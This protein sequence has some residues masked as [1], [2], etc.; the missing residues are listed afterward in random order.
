M[1]A[2]PA[3][4]SYTV[5]A[6]NLSHA[7]ENKIHDD[8]IAQKLGFTGGL[9]PGVE[10]YAYATHLALGRWGRA[11]LEGGAMDCRFQ[12]PVY[13]GAFATV[14]GID[15]GATIAL[16]VESQGEA[17][18]S[19]RASLPREVG[20]APALAELP[21]R[22]PP[23]M[24]DRP[25]ATPR[26]LAPGTRLGIAPFVLTEALW[27]AYLGDVREQHPIYSAERLAHPGQLLRLCNS[28]LRENVVLPPW[29]HTG[30]KVQNYATAGVGDELSARASV[31]DNYERKGHRLVDVDVVLIANDRKV[32][33]RVLHTAIYQLRHLGSG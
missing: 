14:T 20:P 17:C 19:G 1:N 6:Y 9:V 11:W 15:E 29:I 24:A 23:A 33:A 13:D 28:V 26:S 31:L 32:L 25:P 22:T 7:S 8:T 18:A 21:I 3:L 2:S 30:S 16:K 27:R 5:E 10:V 4:A 12:K